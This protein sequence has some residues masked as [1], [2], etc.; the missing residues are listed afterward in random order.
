[1]KA[2]AVGIGARL[3]LVNIFIVVAV[4]SA[5]AK[6]DAR[7]G[8]EA[9]NKDFMA[10]FGRQDAA[11]VANCYTA[12]AQLLPPQ[13][14]FVE[15]TEAIQQFWQSGIDSGAKE[16]ALTTVEVRGWDDEAYEV[17]TYTMSGGGGETLDAGKYIVIWKRVDG[18][19]KLHRDIWN[20]NGQ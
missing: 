7:A 1:M 9:A 14:A 2:I 19:W 15:G 20:S 13:A 17:G 11:R 3:I 4:T 8:I 18:Q 5:A 12:D 10:A 16:F 6:D